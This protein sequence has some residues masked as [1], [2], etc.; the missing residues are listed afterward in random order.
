MAGWILDPNTI[1]VIKAAIH[2]TSSISTPDIKFSFQISQS[3]A[4]DGELSITKT[5]AGGA[6][7]GFV[8]TGISVTRIEPLIGGEATTLVL[9][10]NLLT[11]ATLEST[12]DFQWAQNTSNATP[13]VL[14]AGSYIEVIKA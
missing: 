6:I 10:A 12:L 1:Y 8:T 2:V 4:S 7:T 11:H 14:G 3:P 5:T 13:T 9:N